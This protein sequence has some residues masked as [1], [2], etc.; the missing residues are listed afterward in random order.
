MSAHSPR[1]AIGA[2]LLHGRGGYRSAG[3]H[4]YIA[5]LLRHLPDAD[6]DL[7]LILF[8][9]HP[10]ID[11]KATIRIETSRWKTDRPALRILW[12]QLILPVWCGVL[13]PICC[14]RQRLSRRWRRRV[15][16]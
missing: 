12:E 15:Q 4:T 11:L 7:Q 2:H 6:P 1:I 10:P 16:P 14:T 8:T 13:T 3:I 9:Q 5:E